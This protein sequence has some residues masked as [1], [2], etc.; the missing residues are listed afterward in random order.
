MWARKSVCFRKFPYSFAV[1]K[2]SCHVESLEN[3]ITFVRVYQ[4]RDVVRWRLRRLVPPH[5]S[6][7]EV[8]MCKSPLIHRLHPHVFMTVL[9]RPH[10]I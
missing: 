5:R 4:W 3:S 6:I 7:L 1:A 2:F 10:R 8:H 9:S